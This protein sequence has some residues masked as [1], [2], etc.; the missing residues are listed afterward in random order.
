M[1]Q[2]SWRH[3]FND[4]AR[5]YIDV[6]G[7]KKNG[8][9]LSGHIYNAAAGVEWLPWRHVGLGAEYGRT[10]IRLDQ[11]ERAYNASLAMQLTGPSLFMRVRF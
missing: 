7:V 6:S 4:H 5:V 1:L 11:H 3:A 8:G 9:R 10:R 2:L